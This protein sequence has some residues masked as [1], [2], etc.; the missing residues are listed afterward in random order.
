MCVCV[1]VKISLKDSNSMKQII[2]SLI[3][4]ARS[5]YGLKQ[6]GRMWYN[7]LS[8]HLLKEIYVN[9][10]ICLCTFI[11]KLEPNLQLLLCMLMI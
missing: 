9:S 1:C 4:C 10:P 3:G 6:S 7:C 5:L 2:Q 11:K 8:E